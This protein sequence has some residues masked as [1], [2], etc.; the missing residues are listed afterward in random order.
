MGSA[1]RRSN[2]NKLHEPSSV[3]LTPQLPQLFWNALWLLQTWPSSR[4]WKAKVSLGFQ[5]YPD[6]SCLPSLM[7][8][9]LSLYTLSLKKDRIYSPI[10]EAEKENSIQVIGVQ[11]EGLDHLDVCLVGVC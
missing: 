7:P 5:C 8:I 1:D 4:Y 2:P 6:K 9:F 3:V 11:D 10:V